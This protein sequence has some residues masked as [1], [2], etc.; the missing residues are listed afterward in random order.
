[1]L[2][3][4]G[5]GVLGVLWFVGIWFGGM[6]MYGFDLGGLELM[7]RDSFKLQTSSTLYLPLTL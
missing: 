1:M 4:E 5:V 6:G 7:R 2:M 3:G